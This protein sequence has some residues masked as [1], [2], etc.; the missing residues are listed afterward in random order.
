MGVAE[1]HGF[2]AAATDVVPLAA[3]VRRGAVGVPR[4]VALNDLR[5]RFAGYFGAADGNVGGG[6]LSGAG[7]D[8]FH[9]AKVAVPLDEVA[10]APT[11]PAGLGVGI[12]GVA[13]VSR[14]M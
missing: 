3:R 5:G 12:E 1:E 2:G 7:S 10:I 6:E 9:A 11:V 8:I 13:F 4:P 14:T